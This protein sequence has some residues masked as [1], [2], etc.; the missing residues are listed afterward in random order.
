MRTPNFDNMLAVLRREVPSRPTL[1]EFYLNW[2]LYPRLAGS[3]IA[4]RTDALSW[5]RTAIH[6][7]ANAGYDYTTLL[8]PGFGFPRAEQHQLSSRSLNEGAMI[9]DRASFDAYTWPDPDAVEYSF[10]DAVAPELPKGMKF[11]VH[12][13]DGVLENVIGVAGYENLCIMLYEDP[14]LVHD[15]FVEV[16]TR[17]ARYYERALQYDVVGAIIANDDW[18]FKT[19]TMLGTEDMRTYVFPWHKRI[20][21][22]A[23]AAGRPAILHS[24]GE[25]SAVMDEVIDEIKFDA[26]HSAEDTILPIE[27]MYE[28]WGSRIA[29]LGGIDIDFLVRAT[30]EAITARCAAMMERAATRGGYALGSGNS[31]PEYVPDD[32]YFAMIKAAVGEIVLPA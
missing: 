7:Y 4:S 9:V 14:E 28:R 18:G 11:I 3:A 20:V 29:L 21:E 13:P 31:I 12:G 26:K 15:I 22:S 27:E 1:F 6:A 19:Q 16:G 23:H 32:H 10:L 24:C 30:P 8:I 17:L 25:L 2:R 5:I